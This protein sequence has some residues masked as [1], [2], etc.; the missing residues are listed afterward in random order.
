MKSADFFQVC[1]DEIIP[2][3]LLSVSLFDPVKVYTQ[4]QNR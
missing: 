4:L 3:T 1:L 2:Q